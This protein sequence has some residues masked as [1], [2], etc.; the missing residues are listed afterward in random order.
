[1]RPGVRSMFAHE[2]YDALVVG[3]RC[4]GAA[5][6]M[7]MARKGT[8]GTRH[9]SRRLRH[10]YHL[11]ACADAWRSAATASL[12]RAAAPAGDGHAGGAGDDVP[13]WRRGDRPSRSGRRMAWTRCMRRA[14]P[15]STARSWM[16]RGKPVRWCATAT[17][18]SA[19][20]RPRRTRLRRDGSGRRR[21]PLAI[22]SDLVVG[23]DGIGSSVARLAGAETVQKRA[24][25]PR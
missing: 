7:L 11:H 1:M 12:G 24:T 18:S 4:A 14:G 9:R 20:P 10:G 2:S 17:R 23:A 21:P 25:P 19:D 22:R 13:L 5:T 15:C 6:A 8:S 3:A 16:R